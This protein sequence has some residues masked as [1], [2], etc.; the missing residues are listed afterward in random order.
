MSGQIPVPVMGATRRPFQIPFR[1]DCGGGTATDVGGVTDATVMDGVASI[2][3]G[4]TGLFT[5]TF[6][7]R[8][9]HLLHVEAKVLSASPA[10]TDYCIT[11]A[12]VDG[13]AADNSVTIQV[14]IGGANANTDGAIV[15]GIAYFSEI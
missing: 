8:H 14:V 7:S 2:A 4:G 10:A 1:F 9:E 13:S 6:L 3:D 5:I 12:W 15:T 11:T